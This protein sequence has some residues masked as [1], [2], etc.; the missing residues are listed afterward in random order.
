MFESDSLISL[1]LTELFK[2]SV[3]CDTKSIV[4]SFA[5]IT[6]VLRLVDTCSFHHKF[7]FFLKRSSKYTHNEGKNSPH[8]S[9]DKIYSLRYIFSNPEKP[10]ERK[11]QYQ[12]NSYN[13]RT[14]NTE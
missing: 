12:A 4:D 8:K 7:H 2:I 9:V 1:I 3:S 6:N 5:Q 13:S 10:E 11:A 14:Q